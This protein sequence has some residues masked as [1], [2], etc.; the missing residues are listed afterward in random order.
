MII[1]I[2]LLLL[3]FGGMIGATVYVLKKSDPKNVDTSLR[4]DITTSQ[5]FLPFVDIQ[6]NMILLG[7]HDYRSIVEVSSVNYDLKSALEKERIEVQ[8]AQFLNSLSFDITIFLA[9]RELDFDDYLEKMKEDYQRT[10]MDF[11][12]LH[13]FTTRNFAEMEQMKEFLGVKRQKKKYIIIPYNEA[14]KLSMQTDEEKFE[15]SR[16]ELETRVRIV[17]EG[18]AP[19]GLTVTLLR[20]ADIIDLLVKTYHRNGKS[21]GL[22]IANKEYTSLLVESPKNAKELDMTTLERID[23]YLSQVE[24]RIYNNILYNPNVPE[25][26]KA[27]AEK[28]YEKIRSARRDHENGGHKVDLQEEYY[29]EL[30]NKFM[31]VKKDE[32]EEKKPTVEPTRERSHANGFDDD[33]EEF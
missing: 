19:L 4:D 25:D 7:N 31:G 24:E 30:E 2:L 20:E 10:L 18:L 6:K 8:Y 23:M 22:Q 14:N 33:Y 15:H 9:T 3:M 32:I 27:E 11:P 29:D 26:E 21:H 17:Q 16:R 13:E 28:I 12:G 5:E 1:G